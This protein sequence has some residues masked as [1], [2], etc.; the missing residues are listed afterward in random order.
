MNEQQE[1][2]DQ[3]PPE[4]Q[5]QMAPG[6]PLSLSHLHEA[7]WQREQRTPRHLLGSGAC[8]PLPAENKTS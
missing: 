3:Y 6:F 4:Y 2:R 1:Q 5:D 8:A 7:S